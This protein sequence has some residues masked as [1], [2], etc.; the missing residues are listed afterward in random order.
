VVEKEASGTYFKGDQLWRLLDAAYGGLWPGFSA[1][2]CCP[3]FS[4]ETKACEGVKPYQKLKECLKP[5]R[6]VVITLEN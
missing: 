3:G 6:R 5:D 1:G 4:I 2:H